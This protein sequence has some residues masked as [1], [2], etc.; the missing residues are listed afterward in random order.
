MVLSMPLMGHLLDRFRTEYMFAA[1]LVVMMS[2]LI[3]V[4]FVRDLPT[5]LAYG[6][7]FGLNNAASLTLY[8]FMWPRYFG[9]R[10]LGSIQGTGQMIAVVG[11]SLGPLP[12]GIAFDLFGSYTET[13]LVLALQPLVCAGL[14][15][16]LRAPAIDRGET[17]G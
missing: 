10:H 6:V 7:I 13:L 12:L 16:L 5:A 9:R 15:L 14:A 11:A 17:I 4:T 2:S 8:G 1:A 3:A